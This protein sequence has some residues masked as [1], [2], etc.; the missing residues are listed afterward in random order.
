MSWRDRRKPLTESQRETGR[1]RAESQL[2]ETGVWGYPAVTWDEELGVPTPISKGPDALG[3]S[4]T[5]WADGSPC[6]LHAGQR[7]VHPGVGN[8]FRHGGGAERVVGA[9][10]MAHLIARQLD[11]S[12]WEALLLTVKRAAAWSQFYETKLAQ[13]TDDEELRPGGVFHDWVVA[14]E[15]V[16]DKLAR[17]SKMAVD[18]GVAAIMVQQ[19]RSEGETIA[20]VLNQAIGTAG[21]DEETEQ[22]LRT[23]LRAALLEVDTEMREL[24]GSVAGTEEPDDAVA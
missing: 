5:V 24:T 13:C 14:Y 20:R 4:G 2:R 21:L 10:M 8:C 22:R 1:K 12:P 19:A 7:T 6:K 17:Y 9:W 3:C 11:V 15:R 18:A 16:T 23:A